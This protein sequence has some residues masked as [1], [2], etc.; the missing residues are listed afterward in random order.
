MRDYNK[1]INSRIEWIR[2]NIA[3]ARAA[4][5]I[6]GLS[7][8]KDSAIVGALCKKACE[9]VLG[10][11]MPCGNISEDREYALDFAKEFAIETVEIDLSAPYE[12]LKDAIE[13]KVGG[14]EG[15]C[16][17]NIKPRLRMATLYA[18]AQKKNLLVAGTG[19]H[20]ERMMGYFTKWGDG[21]FDFNPVSDL[22]YTEMLELGEALEIPDRYI[23]R[24]P[25]AG[26]W[27]GQTDEQE[28]GVSYRA[29]DKFLNEG[30]GEAED[31]AKIKKAYER[32]RHKR[33]GFN[34][35]KPR[36]I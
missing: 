35:Y 10:A 18:M 26:L 29:I 25:S 12:A 6:L 9:N 20:S 13:V 16:A 32:S 27:K 19:N 7:G 11:V 22:T 34:I 30:T 4:G 14:I 33:L 3:Q 36:D 1:E 17:S 28:M 23:K 21:V 5:I 2:M 24:T 15:L 31:I 8:G